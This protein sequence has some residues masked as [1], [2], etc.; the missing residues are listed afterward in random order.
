MGAP[1]VNRN[2]K[3]ILTH[4]EVKIKNLW[5]GG[6]QYYFGGDV[7]GVREKLCITPSVCN[8]HGWWNVTGK[9]Q[10]CRC[11]WGGTK[12]KNCALVLWERDIIKN[13]NMILFLYVSKGENGK[14]CICCLFQLHIQTFCCQ[15]L[16]CD[17]SK[18]KS[19]A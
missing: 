6:M 17:K 1:F 11:S 7:G 5:G 4:L 19:V 9:V 16:S 15:P 18:K 3:A 10:V 8:L 12:V 14:V 13:N 2:K